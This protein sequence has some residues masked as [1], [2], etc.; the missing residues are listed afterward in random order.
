MRMNIYGRICHLVCI[1]SCSSYR[2]KC[3]RVPLLRRFT[4]ACLYRRFFLCG[5]VVIRVHREERTKNTIEPKRFFFLLFFFLLRPHL[6][7]CFSLLYP[8]RWV[9]FFRLF[10]ERTQ[11]EREREMSVI[12]GF[13]SFRFILYTLQT[14]EG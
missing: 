4:R 9:N 12:L 3:K 10:S 14:Y 7:F 5:V 8:F 6:F 11:G 2:R 13:F 1:P